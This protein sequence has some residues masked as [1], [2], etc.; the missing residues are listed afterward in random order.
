[1]NRLLIFVASLALS[2]VTISSTCAAE[3]SL[4]SLAPRA[5][6]LVA[7]EDEF[8]SDSG[9]LGPTLMAGESPMYL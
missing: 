7:A 6:A 2:I 4:A 8:A 9:S 1:M 3:P 5:G